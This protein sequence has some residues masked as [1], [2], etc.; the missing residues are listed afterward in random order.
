MPLHRT[1]CK[2]WCKQCR[3]CQ[4]DAVAA[5]LLG[6]SWPSEQTSA[7]PLEVI[8]RY[9]Q[10][11]RAGPVPMKGQTCR[12]TM[13]M[14]SQRAFLAAGFIWRYR[15]ATWIKRCPFLPKA[16]RGPGSV[17]RSGSQQK[18]L[19]FT[20]CFCRRTWTWG[21]HGMKRFAMKVLQCRGSSSLRPPRACAQPA[22][23]AGLH[24]LLQQARKLVA[25]AAGRLHN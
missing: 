15:S 6:S 13:H 25:T 16:F 9:R 2:D 1:R 12:R 3:P 23:A 8:S 4:A 17:S 10:T 22:E 21:H 20:P 18:L 24:M 7:Q 11:P 5:C 14:L 19:P